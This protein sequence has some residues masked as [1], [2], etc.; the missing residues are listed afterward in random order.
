[1][2]TLVLKSLDDIKTIGQQFIELMKDHKVFAFYGEMGAGKTTFIKVICQLLGVE[3]NIT[4]PTFAIVN[5]Y[6]TRQNDLI[7]HFDCYRLKNL[8]EAYDIGAEEYFYSGNICFIEWPEKIE[9]LLPENS[10]VVK[11]TVQANQER[12][13]SIQG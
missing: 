2:E 4:S 7:Y 12:H 10:V 13:I 3:E 6:I 11:I 9:D 1:M 8:T 5:E